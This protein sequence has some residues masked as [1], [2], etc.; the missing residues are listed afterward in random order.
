MLYTCI[1]SDNPRISIKTKSYD[2]TAIQKAFRKV[3]GYVPYNITTKMYIKDST[4]HQRY[5]EIHEKE[6]L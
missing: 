4:F 5:A 6:I 1:D 2:K 3:Y